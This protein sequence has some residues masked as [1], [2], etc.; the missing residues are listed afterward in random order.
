MSVNPHS[1]QVCAR[2]FF[3]NLPYYGYVIIYG[4]VAQVA[5]AV[6]VVVSAPRR[7]GTSVRKVQDYES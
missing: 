1:V 3:C 7:T 5:V 4:I 2:I 6:G